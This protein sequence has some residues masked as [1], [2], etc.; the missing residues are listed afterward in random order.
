[1]TLNFNQLQSLVTVLNALKDEK[2]PFKLSLIIAKNSAMLQKEF[3]FY[4]EQ[5]RKFALEYLE[6]DENGAP[7]QQGENMFKIKDGKQEECAEARQALN[8]FTCDCN[9]RMIP[10]S[11]IENLEMTPAQLEGLE[12]II[13]EEA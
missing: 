5:E 3:D 9:L 7:V 11:L 6:F 1:M 10:L 4:L 13:D 8:E 2:L 12:L